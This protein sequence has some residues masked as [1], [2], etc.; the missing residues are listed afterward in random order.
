MG[1]ILS[2]WVLGRD[3]GEPEVSLLWWN[4]YLLLGVESIGGRWIS[5]VS[6][7]LV[8][9]AGVTEV[10]LSVLILLAVGVGCVMLRFR[11]QAC[12]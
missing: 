12:G 10:V 3:S 1:W 5:A 11:G 6:R 7:L 8:S 4:S 9:V 2:G